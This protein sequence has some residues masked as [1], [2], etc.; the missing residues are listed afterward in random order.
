MRLEVA[1]L[2]HSLAHILA[3]KF[4]A[5]AAYGDIALA[6]E[7]VQACLFGIKSVNGDGAVVIGLGGELAHGAQL[8][9]VHIPFAFVSHLQQFGR[10]ECDDRQ[11]AVFEVIVAQSQGEFPLCAIG[12]DDGMCQVGVCREH[13]I[14]CRVGRE[15]VF[16]A[17]VVGHAQFAEVANFYL[18]FL[19]LRLC[20][21][22]DAQGG[23][24]GECSVEA[25]HNALGV[26]LVV[27]DIFVQ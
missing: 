12:E 14:A 6:G 19:F 15:E 5:S 2:N 16:H 10:V 17:Q 20:S 25:V 26:R 21:C 23:D 13:S 18:V 22:G 27:E 9:D 3:L 7:Y 1:S 11:L 4:L 24:D 8:P